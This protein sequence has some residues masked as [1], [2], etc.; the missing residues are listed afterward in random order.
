MQ[1]KAEHGEPFC[2]MLIGN[3]YFWGDF[4]AIQGRVRED[5]DSDDAVQSYLRENYAK[6]EDWLW[7]AIGMGS[8]WPASTWAI[9]TETENRVSSLPSRSRSGR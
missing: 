5:F 9:F 1:D 3:L 7:R 4:A 2:Q 6:C 8:P